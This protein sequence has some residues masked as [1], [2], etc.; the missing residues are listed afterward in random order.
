M[1]LGNTHPGLSPTIKAQR[2]LATL[3]TFALLVVASL[4]AHAQETD[5]HSPPINA[6][7]TTEQVVKN[8]I[9]MNL[10]RTHALHSYAGTRT[11]KLEYHGL[12]SN[13]NAEMVVDMKFRAPATKEFSI[14]SATGSNMVIEKVF[15]KL[16]EAEKESL[17]EETQ[18]RTALNND[19]Y[20]FRMVGYESKPFDSTYVLFV[21]PKTS[22][23]FLY[24][25]R[26]WVDAKDF[27]V[28]RLQAE[29][30]KNP[31]FW[32]KNSEIE[33]RYTKVNDFWLP[34]H[35]HTITSIRLGG[36]AE[37]TIEYSNYKITAADA[38]GESHTE[39]TALATDTS[40]LQ[41]SRDQK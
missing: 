32:I 9:M 40:Q 13:R 34:T 10:E 11:Y 14:R 35:N 12:P 39:E 2:R 38:V 22:N 30:S 31:S 37:L 28:V 27:A 20:E 33:H 5:R 21:E 29:P 24:R 16:L 23:K 8:M 3:L 19:N 25:G 36:R 15:K 26:I 6:P 18:R 41:N 1:K 7:L 17:T 4:P